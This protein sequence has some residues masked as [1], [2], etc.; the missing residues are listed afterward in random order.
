MV[1]FTGGDTSGDATMKAMRGTPLRLTCRP[2]SGDMGG[3]ATGVATALLP[4][5]TWSEP[6]TVGECAADDSPDGSVGGRSNGSDR[7]E[8]GRASGGP[9]CSLLLPSPSSGR[10]PGTATGDTL[11]RR[12]GPAE[13]VPAPL[14]PGSTVKGGG[15][16][17]VTVTVPISWPTTV[18]VLVPE[19]G[20][21]GADTPATAASLG[22]IPLVP[23]AVTGSPPGGM[24]VTSSSCLPLASGGRCSATCGVAGVPCPVEDDDV[25]ATPPLPH[26]AGV[27]AARGVVDVPANAR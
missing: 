23:A 16:P 8:G 15:P 19:E 20:V 13:N 21:G 14:T 18:L 24:V 22:S 27:P 1:P 25:K 26:V 10:P 4:E 3:S 9:A 12:V 6:S 5:E 7:A 11:A 17:P 2:N